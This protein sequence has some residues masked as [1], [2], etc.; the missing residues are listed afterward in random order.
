MRLQPSVLAALRGS[1]LGTSLLVG[2]G[3][4]QGSATSNESTPVTS[5]STNT[6]TIETASTETTTTSASTSNESTTS[7]ESTETSAVTPVENI[8]PPCGRG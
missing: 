1:V 6:N 7:S 8:P 4:S 3:A 2:C 5:A